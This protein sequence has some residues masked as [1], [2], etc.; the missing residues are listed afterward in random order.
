MAWRLTRRT[1]R[2][3]LI[4]TQVAAARDRLEATLRTAAEVV[5]ALDV[6]V[7]AEE[8]AR[9]R[10]AADEAARRERAEEASERAAAD[11]RIQEERSEREAAERAAVS[12]THLTLPT[13]CSV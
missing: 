2:K 6:D 7:A 12:Y 1:R 9:E 13:I 11:A 10:A 8:E 5:D 3:T 4:Y